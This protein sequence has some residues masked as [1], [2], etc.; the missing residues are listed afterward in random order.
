MQSIMEH[1]Y[2]RRA[3]QKTNYKK[4]LS[5]LVSGKNR[6]VARKTNL[7]MHLQ[8]VVHDAKGDVIKFSIS[9]KALKAH[10]WTANTGNVSAC[11]LTGYLFGK[12]VASKKL[13]KELV[14]DIGLQNAQKKGRLFAALKGAIDSGLNIDANKD[15]FPDLDR[16][17]GKLIKKEDLFNK[18]KTNVDK[19]N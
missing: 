18:T 13:S 17:S 14:F 9:S 5:L 12:L 6:L 19:I 8:Y 16:I 3:E 15:V 4:R 10:G 7:Y 11:Y 2:K 1:M